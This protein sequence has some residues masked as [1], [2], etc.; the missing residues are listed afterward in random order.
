M[1]KTDAGLRHGRGPFVCI[2]QTEADMNYIEKTN[3]IDKMGSKRG[4]ALY[5]FNEEAY[6]KSP[7]FKI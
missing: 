6:R 5:Q 3:L 2:N 7:N 4:A 1:K